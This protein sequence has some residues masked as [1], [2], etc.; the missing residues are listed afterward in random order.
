MGESYK[1]TKRRPNGPLNT[2]KTVSS[3]IRNIKKS[4]S[5]IFFP[6]QVRYV[7]QA[8]V[9]PGASGRRTLPSW[10]LFFLS[11]ND[12]LTTDTISK[13]KSTLSLYNAS[14]SYN[15]KRPFLSVINSNNNNN[16]GGNDNRLGREKKKQKHAENVVIRK[17]KLTQHSDNI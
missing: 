8:K 13:K 2:T 5:N 9:A 6:L 1:K 3:S 7:G 14:R 11:Y 16:D 17:P 10:R 15:K 4:S 12:L